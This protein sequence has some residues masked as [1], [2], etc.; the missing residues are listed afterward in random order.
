MQSNAWSFMSQRVE[1]NCVR[2]SGMDRQR[3][4]PIILVSFQRS[5]DVISRARSYS[6]D[7]SLLQPRNS[8]PWS[9]Q[10]FAIFK[11]RF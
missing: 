10:N 4:Q 5:A 8:M 6:I 9:R 7:V 3:F 11:S 1:L 2:L